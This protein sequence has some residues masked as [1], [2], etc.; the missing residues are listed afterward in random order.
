MDGQEQSL[1]LLF[2]SINEETEWVGGWDKSI[3]YYSDGVGCLSVLLMGLFT[4]V[5]QAYRD[6]AI[7]G[8]VLCFKGLGQTEV[9]SLGSI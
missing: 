7:E 9:I 8:F 6:Y 2:K 5:W 1:F 3:L 4:K